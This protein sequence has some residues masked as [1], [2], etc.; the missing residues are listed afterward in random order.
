MS[1]MTPEKLQ[2]LIEAALMVYGKPM[3][4]DKLMQLFEEEQRPSTSELREAISAL[5]E[6]YESRG[7]ELKE[8][9]S[10]YRFQAKQEY[11]SWIARLWEERAPRYSRALL[12]TMAL[13]AYRQPI[14]R[15]EIEDVRGVSVSSHIVKTLLEREWVRVVGHRD[16][17]GR[18]ALYAT[19]KDFL[20][21][22]NLKSL[23]E[24]PTLSEIRDL[25]K[26]N[27]ELD[28]DESQS[29][30]EKASESN[31]EELKQ[32]DTAEHETDSNTGSEPSELNA[33]DSD[34]D[35]IDVEQ[36]ESEQPVS[37]QPD[38]GQQKPDLT[39]SDSMG[40]DTSDP[41]TSE[42]E[43]IDFETDS[44][45]DPETDPV[46]ASTD[47]VSNDDEQNISDSTSNKT[48]QQLAE[49]ASI[50]EHYVKRDIS[51]E[52]LME[53]AD[54]AKSDNLQADEA[55][56][57]D[58]YQSEELESDV[59]DSDRVDSE[60][61]DSNSVE[62]ESNET[63]LDESEPNETQAPASGN[64]DEETA[65]KSTESSSSDDSEPY[66]DENKSSF[67]RS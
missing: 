24:L 54:L 27:A 6:S 48:V 63:D 67:E 41:D 50:N 21:Y 49:E 23:E 66:E 32:S 38:S 7:V 46:E 51:D 37:E 16:V 65:E 2:N 43:A 12:E 36:S 57:N 39:V 31:T 44:E 26:I 42:S 1:S 35:S 53:E 47:D 60:T 52:E 11:A 45:T 25:D 14:T 40:S 18:P 3:S 34:S 10:G 28:F 33:T 5:N 58:A 56:F 62:S 55:V 59:V 19:T 13:I 17:P 61:V 29:G 20:D 9:A 30:D 15:S 4:I 22:F 8:V 64:I